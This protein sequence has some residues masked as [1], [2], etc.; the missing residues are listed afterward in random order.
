VTS[1]PLPE[2]AMSAFPLSIGTSLAF[3]SLFE[4]RQDPYDPE[5]KIPVKIDINKYSELYINV[6]T[7]IRNMLSAVN[8][9]EIVNI[10]PK[11]MVPYIENELG[12]I[13]DIMGI[14]GGG[15]CTPIFYSRD[16]SFV[17][18]SYGTAVVRYRIPHTPK[19]KLHELLHVESTKILL[20]D[21]KNDFIKKVGKELVDGHKKTDLMISH[22]PYDLLSHKRFDK[23]DLL[24]S[25]TGELKGR[26]RWYTKYYNGSNLVNIPFQRKLLAI[27]G[28]KELIHP[29]EMKLRNMVIEI[30]NKCNWNALTTEA[31]VGQDL[32]FNIKERYIIQEFYNKL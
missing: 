5:R 16:Y 4:G 14:E 30:A 18:R 21:P 10:A 26:D 13:V 3:E 19:Q 6:D 22:I 11:D 12:L 15:V 27:F 25:N 20:K 32:D 8:G 9:E 1:N 2:R 31:K 23:L 28:D 7:I 17:K 29:T 24:E